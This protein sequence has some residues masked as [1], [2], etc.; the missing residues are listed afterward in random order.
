MKISPAGTLM[1]IVIML[2]MEMVM[3]MLMDMVMRMLREMVRTV[4]T[5]RRKNLYLICM[6]RWSRMSIE[7]VEMTNKIGTN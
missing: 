3:G 1:L 5:R 7:L 4:R 2:M 6:V